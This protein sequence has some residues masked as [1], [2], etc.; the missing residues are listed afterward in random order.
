LQADPARAA[1]LLQTSDRRKQEPRSRSCSGDEGEARAAVDK[2]AAIIL[3][4]SGSIG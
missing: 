4:R 2:G 1:L 3:R